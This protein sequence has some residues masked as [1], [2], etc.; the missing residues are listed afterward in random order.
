MQAVRDMYGCA[1][2]C[3]MVEGDPFGDYNR[4]E[5]QAGADEE[6][7]QRTR[8]D[9]ATREHARVVMASPAGDKIE[10]CHFSFLLLPR[11]WA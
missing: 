2:V 3:F 7:E 4:C 11:T 10:A 8:E 6:D 9:D 5:R 1:V